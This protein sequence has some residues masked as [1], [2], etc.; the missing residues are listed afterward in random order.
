VTPQP[1]SDYPA[2]FDVTEPN[3]SLYGLGWDVQDYRGAKLIWHG[4][5]VFGSL[6]AV[7]LL[8]DRNV[9]LYIAVNSEEGEVVR[10]LLYELLDHYLGL[11]HGRW[12]EQFHEFKMARL[13]AAAKEVQ[14]AAAAPARV[15]PSL[16]LDRYAGDYTDPWYGTIKVRRLGQG[17]TIAFPHSK[18]MDGPLT[19]HQ[20]DTFR[21]NPSLKWIEPAFVTFALD[22]DGKVDRVTMKPVSPL[23]DFSF[24]YQDLL[25]T[26]AKTPN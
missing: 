2:Q 9:G 25:F 23:A 6:A 3:F 14:K 12:P 17:L 10:G 15:G 19:H 18:G 24:D 16:P 5:A 8:P 22:A 11:P 1:I 13:N 20:Y 7:A 26:P 21:M 4:G